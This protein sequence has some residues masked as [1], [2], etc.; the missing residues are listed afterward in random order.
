[1]GLLEK[2]F[3]PSSYVENIENITPERLKNMGVKAVMTD[4]D[5]TLVAFDE[6]H[7]DDRVIQWFQRLEDSNIKVMI[8]SNGKSARVGDFA[9]PYDYKYIC[10]ARKPLSKNFKQA[11]RRM[12]AE[13]SETVMIGDQLMTDIFGAN[14]IHMKSILVIPVKNKDGLATYINRRLERMLMKYF[15]KRGLLIKE[16]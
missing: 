2:F 10:N 8:V 12:N 5:N 14:L 9:A 3:L 11:A 7:A 4:L 13:I 16:D 6:A 1:M 15:K